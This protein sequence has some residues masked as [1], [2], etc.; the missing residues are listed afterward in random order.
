M[1]ETAV[2]RSLADTILDHLPP[3]AILREAVVRIGSLE[4]LDPAGLESAWFALDEP[5][6][7]VDASLT[8]ISMPV[9]I[10]CGLCDL[11]HTP[12]EPAYLVCPRCGST[13]PRV[14]SGWGVILARMVVEIPDGTRLAM[15]PIHAHATHES[16]PQAP[17][18]G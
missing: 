13:R 14:L 9:R 7:L 5:A 4:H 11:E 10:H 12:E 6:A 1:H 17:E 3:H 8:L 18:N 16:Y 2:V 15:D